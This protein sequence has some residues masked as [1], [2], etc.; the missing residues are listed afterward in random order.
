MNVLALDTA[1]PVPAIALLWRGRS[2]EERLSAD[3]RA[4]EELLPALSRLLEAAGASLA[5][6]SRIA[7]CSGP[8]SFTGVRIGLATAWGLGRALAIPVEAV[9]TLEAIAEAVR[10]P[11]VERIAAALDAGR[12]EAVFERF[13]LGPDR[14]H[15][16]GGV[17]RRSLEAAAL[18]LRGEEVVSLPENLLGIPARALGVSPALAVARAVERA[19]CDVDAPALTA[20]YAR[21]SA[22]E[23]KLGAP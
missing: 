10:A 19:P 20:I 14:A 6:C 8:G 7:V 22:A 13:S 5:D 23:E 15:S 12:G 16:R 9:P 1:S 18:A 4:S 11:G 2:F 21:A 17:E 3:R